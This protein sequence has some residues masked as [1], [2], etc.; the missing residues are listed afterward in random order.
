MANLTLKEYKGIEV[1]LEEL[2]LTESAVSSY[3]SEKLAALAQNA[4]QFEMVDRKASEG[5]LVNLEYEGFID[6]IQFDGGTADNCDLI[7]GS[8][9]FIPGFE[10][11]LLGCKA[12]ETTYVKIQFPD[13]YF[14]EEYSGKEAVFCCKIHAVYE[15]NTPEINDEYAVKSGYQDLNDMIKKYADEAKNMHLDQIDENLEL[16][17]MEVLVGLVE[18]EVEEEAVESQLDKM[19]ADFADGLANA[20]MEFADYLKETGTDEK[21]LRDSY[22]AN[23]VKSVKLDAAL[24]LIRDAENIMV[25][26]A[27]IE[28]EYH[29]LME[30]YSLTMDDMHEYLPEE[31]LADNLLRAKC[32]DVVKKNAKITWK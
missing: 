7:L 15:P 1:T 13:P 28:A 3:V 12:G 21:A 16:E 29:R 2:E 5:D 32:M 4:T 27:E 6:G 8:G 31:V 17:A 24:M 19:I 10:E 25:T 18:G 9:R 22:R 23:A 14:Y 11:Q 20:G 30:A 26:A